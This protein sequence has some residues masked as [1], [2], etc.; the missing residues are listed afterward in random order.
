MRTERAPEQR[1]FTLL[2][3][4]VALVILALA[5]GFA[6]R[7]VS[8]GTDRLSDAG[9]ERQAVIVAD[10]VLA[11]LGHTVPVRPGRMKGSDSGLG[12]VIEIGTVLENP[13]PAA[14]L[15]A[16]PLT[17]SVHYQLRGVDRTFELQSVRLGPKD[18][19]S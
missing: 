8:E 11:S 7:T 15:A 18:A 10:S 6:V 14:G 9:A 16:Y 4:L 19:P 2:E 12:W 17:I 1:G 5:A 3:V 13:P